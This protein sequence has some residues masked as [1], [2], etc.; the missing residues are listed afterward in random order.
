MLILYFIPKAGLTL[1]CDLKKKMN[2]HFRYCCGIDFAFVLLLPFN[3]IALQGG[4]SRWKKKIMKEIII[5]AIEVG[6]SKK[7]FCRTTF[8]SVWCNVMMFLHIL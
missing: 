1:I 5:I 8:G 6:F 7:L 2:R 3:Q 4:V